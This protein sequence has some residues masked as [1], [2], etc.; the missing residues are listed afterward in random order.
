MLNT[1]A[2]KYYIMLIIVLSNNMLLNGQTISG[3]VSEKGSD[4]PIMAV[5]IGII[6]KNI[7][8]FTDQNGK[9]ALQITPEYYNDTLRFSCVGYYSYS[10]K[11]SDFIK[12]N[13]WN[14]SLEQKTYG[15]GEVTVSPGKFKQKLLGNTKSP[16]SMMPLVPTFEYGIFIRNNKIAFINE[17]YLNIEPASIRHKEYAS[18]NTCDTVLFRIT[19]YNAHKNKFIEDILPQQEFLDPM[20]VTLSE[21]EIKNKDKRNKITIDLRHHNFVVEGDFLIS[22]ENLSCRNLSIGASYNWNG[23]LKNFRKKVTPRIEEW[24]DIWIVEPSEMN[25]S[26]LVD[27]EK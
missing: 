13:N 3:V 9:Y 14:V 4:I 19:V 5:S 26:V 24:R 22:I 15:L 17:V 10:V 16:D 21:Q 6:G 8:A 2:M 1:N 27:I 18:K 23:S 20:Y 12:L 11:I 25:L 7:G